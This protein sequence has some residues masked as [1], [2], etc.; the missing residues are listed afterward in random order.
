MMA[1]KYLGK[2]PVFVAG[3]SQGVGYEIVKQ[4]TQLG[5]PVHALVRREVSGIQVVENSFAYMLQVFVWYTNPTSFL[6][7]QKESKLLLEQIV[8]VTVTLGDA[9]D[10]SAIQ[11]VFDKVATS[12]RE[13]LNLC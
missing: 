5:T 12:T 11:K 7:F 1:S 8:G 4:L 6:H 13:F 2:S 3:G 9:L 10:E